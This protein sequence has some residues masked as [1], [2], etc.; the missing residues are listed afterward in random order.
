MGAVGEPIYRVRESV[1]DGFGKEKSTHCMGKI[2]GLYVCLCVCV[3]LCN[4]L[5]VHDDKRYLFQ[6]ADIDS[7]SVLSF[8]IAC[9][10]SFRPSTSKSPSKTQLAQSPEAILAI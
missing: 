4:I 2:A 6:R 5:D 1:R 8:S 9:V 3:F 7:F 10:S